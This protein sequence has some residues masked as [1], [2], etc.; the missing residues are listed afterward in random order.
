VVLQS[1]SQG[2]VFD[3]LSFIVVPSPSSQ[4]PSLYGLHL[5]SNNDLVKQLDHPE[6]KEL[7]LFHRSVRSTI[8]NQSLSA[9]S[10]TEDDICVSDDI[11]V[12]ITTTI[13]I[14]IAIT[15]TFNYHCI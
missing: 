12:I 15:I 1:H 9:L 8:L 10:V 6:R 7:A 11:L 2:P 5:Q 4:I 3:I 13:I 14:I